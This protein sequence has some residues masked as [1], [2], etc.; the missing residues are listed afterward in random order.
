MAK[1]RFNAF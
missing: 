1:K